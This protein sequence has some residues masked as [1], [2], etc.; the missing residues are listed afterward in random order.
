[1]VPPPGCVRASD[2]DPCAGVAAGCGCDAKVFGV[3]SSGFMVQGL[4]IMGLG[5]SDRVG[6]RAHARQSRNGAQ[7]RRLHPPHKRAQAGAQ[8]GRA[9]HLL[10]GRRQSHACARCQKGRSG[11]RRRGRRTSR[12]HAPEEATHAGTAPAARLSRACPRGTPSLLIDRSCLYRR[13]CAI[14]MSDH[15]CSQGSL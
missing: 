10:A 13:S 11:A 3:Q 2:S 15:Q 1:M 4:G 7:Q 9:P 14:F 12:A 5:F 8:L 6:A